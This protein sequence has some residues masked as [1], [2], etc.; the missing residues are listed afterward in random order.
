MDGECNVDVGAELAAEGPCDDEGESREGV[1]GSES[2][3]SVAAAF[4]F[5][6]LSRIA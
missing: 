5:R 4:S 6:F 2:M 3:P 1:A